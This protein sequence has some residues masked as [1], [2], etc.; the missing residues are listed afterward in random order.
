MIG[1]HQSLSLHEQ[2]CTL[3]YDGIAMDKPATVGKNGPHRARNWFK[4][5]SDGDNSML[6]RRPGRPAAQP[7]VLHYSNY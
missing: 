3:A 4:T 2:R 5:C 1:Q 6:L 7:L